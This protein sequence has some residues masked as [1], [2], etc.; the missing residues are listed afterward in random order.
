MKGK[1]QVKV[2]FYSSDQHDPTSPPPNNYRLE[3]EIGS[4]ALLPD[5]RHLSNWGKTFGC[6]PREEAMALA[7]KVADALGVEVIVENEPEMESYR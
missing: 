1:I 7:R 4:V 6:M 3:V 2:R 5:Y